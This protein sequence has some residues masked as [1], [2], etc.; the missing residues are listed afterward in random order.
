M[1]ETAE[2]AG[3]GHIPC[4]APLPTPPPQENNPAQYLGGLKP[5][6]PQQN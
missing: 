1:R 5:L 3:D 6:L 2:D 4:T